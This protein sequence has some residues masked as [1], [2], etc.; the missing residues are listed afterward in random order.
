MDGQ[1]VVCTMGIQPI[2]L[3]FFPKLVE[4]KGGFFLTT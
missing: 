3:L 2:L 4:F 1:V